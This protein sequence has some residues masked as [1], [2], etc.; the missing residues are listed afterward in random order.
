MIPSLFINMLFGHMVGDYL[1]QNNW[2]ALSKGHSSW[3]CLLHCLVYTA[4]V[5]AF[6]SQ[7]HWQ[8]VLLVLVSHFVI[9][10]WSLADHW[11]ALIR[12]RS[13]HEFYENGHR[14]IPA[15][16]I[17]GAK[18]VYQRPVTDTGENYRI[19]RGGFTTLVY[20]MADNTMHLL[21]MYYGYVYLD[22]YL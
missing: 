14:D 3:R 12:G 8:W 16:W 10:R 4:T 17:N 1:L 19:L 7:W 20:A 2:M 21:V 9:D 11:L 13:L 5:C 15:A 6:M 18:V 22:R